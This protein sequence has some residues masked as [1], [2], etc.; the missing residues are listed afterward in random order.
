MNN[1]KMFFSV[2]MTIV[3]IISSVSVAFV[4][5]AEDY[6]ARYTGSTQSNGMN[7]SCTF[8]INEI[9]DNRFRGV[10]SD[11]GTGIYDF[12][13]NIEGNYYRSGDKITCIF[14]VSFY[15]NRYYSDV[16]VTIRPYEGTANCFCVG[17]WHFENFEM[18]GT[19]FIPSIDTAV[20]NGLYSEEEM[21]LCALLSMV[22]YNTDNIQVDNNLKT[23]PNSDFDLVEFLDSNV[24]SEYSLK[25]NS[26]EIYNYFDG[27]EINTN[28]DD[29]PLYIITK[30]NGDSCK[31]YVAIRGTYKD[32][33][34]GNTEITGTSYDSEKTTHDNFEKAK[35]NI[36]QIIFDYYTDLSTKYEYIDLVVTGHSRGAAVANLY[37]KEATDVIR[38][39]SGIEN[40]PT[41]NSVVAY[42]F[43]CPN[44]A[45]YSSTMET[46]NNI[47]NFCFKED[48]VTTVPLTSPTLGWNYWKYG[49]TLLGTLDFEDFEKL[50]IK[51]GL[52]NDNAVREI[53]GMLSPWRSVHD[54]YN[55]PIVSFAGELQTLYLISVCI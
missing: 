26:L 29:A 23:K 21:K 3:I 54:Y 15:N 44:V 5:K 41:F 55:L 49:V 19:Q 11:S 7:I 30:D 6:I 38:G 47:F 48:L 37:A 52:K 42:K 10:F 33:W 24:F 14:H 28:P 50:T 35:N 34:V 32:E 43:A 17:S 22:T 31:M 20:D 53:H 2:F 36:K 13:E 51:N 8:Q 16:C 9:A 27:R 12:S 39:V 46:Y 18:Y 4:A 40:V 1:K 25:S 45:K